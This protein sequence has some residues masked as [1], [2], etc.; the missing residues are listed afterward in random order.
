MA[1]SKELEETLSL[2]QLLAKQKAT[3]EK[4]LPQH[5]TAERMMR[6]AWVLIRRTPKLMECEA[7]T[8]VE[9]V[10]Q[11]STLGLE[12]GREAHLVPYGKVCVMIPDYKGI[13]ALARR[14]GN[15]KK[16]EAVNVTRRNLAKYAGVQRYRYGEAELEDLVGVTTGP[17]WQEEESLVP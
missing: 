2:A 13:V 12:L 7:S 16:I 1:K 11:A 15:I 10:V 17:P 4:V 5:L 8:V 14:S 6:V 9:S 3:I